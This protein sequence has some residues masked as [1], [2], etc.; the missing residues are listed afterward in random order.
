MAVVN[1]HGWPPEA[2]NA[3]SR[4]GLSG[5]DCMDRCVAGIEFCDVLGPLREGEN[6]F[7]PSWHY[8]L[9]LTPDSGV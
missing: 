6:P 9:S 4:V 5:W 7:R 8:A 2:C 1:V 3:C